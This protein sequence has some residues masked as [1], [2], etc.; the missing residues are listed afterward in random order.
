MLGQNPPR[1]RCEGRTFLPNALPFVS[2]FMEEK[3]VVNVHKLQW[4]VHRFGG[5]RPRMSREYEHWLVGSR[6]ASST[7]YV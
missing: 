7:E 3:I 6:T 2:V 1:G 5:E 4:W